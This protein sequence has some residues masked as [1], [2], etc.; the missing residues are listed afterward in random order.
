M[1]THEQYLAQFEAITKEMLELTRKKNKDYSASQDAF[2]NFTIVERMGIATTEQG[3]LTRMMDKMM[4]LSTFAQGRQLQV[5]D[6]KVED[7]VQDLA[8]YSIL[9]LCY[10]RSKSKKDV[11]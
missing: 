3:F 7:T 4:R 1:M 5:V 6:E 8:V 10:L 2:C 11:E 9:L